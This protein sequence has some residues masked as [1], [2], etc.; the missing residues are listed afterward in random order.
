MTGHRPIRFDRN[1]LAGAFGDLGA[2][3]PLIVGMILAAKLDSASVLLAYGLMQ[4]LT[5]FYYRLPM[6]VQPLKAVATLV[7]TQHIAADVIYGSGL[8]IGIAMLII[9]GVG[10]LDWLV[11]VVPKSVIRGIQLGLAI[12]LSS[13]ALRDY[14][15]SESIRGYILAGLAFAVS[16]A[17]IRNRRV[18]AALVVVGLGLVYAFVFKL[19]VGEL[20]G[21][22][23]LHLPQLHVPTP[24]DVATGFVVL[25]LP[26]L[27][28]SLG[29]SILATRQ[30]AS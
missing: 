3:L 1:E 28:L 18:P 27:P 10:A 16:L 5:G 9:A 24:A 11:R 25:A 26:Q 4:L 30:I 8:A 17:L 20:I 14:V 15:G 6:P 29:N 21:S 19:S 13:L 2:D 23:G 7:I 22:A 12:Q